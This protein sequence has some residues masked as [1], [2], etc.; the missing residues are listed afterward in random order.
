MAHACLV[1][2]DSGKIAAQEG[3]GSAKCRPKTVA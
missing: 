1:D 3:E 2:E